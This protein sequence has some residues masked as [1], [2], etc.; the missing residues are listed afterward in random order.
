M[1]MILAYLGVK[2]KDYVN[3]STSYNTR[4]FFLYILF[5][6]LLTTIGAISIYFIFHAY[7]VVMLFLSCI[8]FML[9]D[10]YKSLIRLL[11][12]GDRKLLDILG[13]SKNQYAMAKE[14]SRK[15]FI[16][17]FSIWTNLILAIC[18]FIFENILF[19][20][21]YMM[22]TFISFYLS[23]VLRIK[24]IELYLYKIRFLTR[25]FLFLSNIDFLVPI[26]TGLILYVYFKNMYREL[27]LTLFD[28][29]IL[30]FFSSLFFFFIIGFIIHRILRKCKKRFLATGVYEFFSLSFS[31]Q[32]SKEK[33][34][35]SKLYPRLLQQ[36]WL[37]FRKN[38]P[39]NIHLLFL[40]N[41]TPLIIFYS[42]LFYLNNNP[43]LLSK[44]L[45]ILFLLY[46]PFIF[47]LQTTLSF[48]SIDL[49][50]ET[51]IHFG[52]I[53]KFI[54]W[55]VLFRTLTS[56]LLNNLFGAILSCSII[57]FL[58]VSVRF[59]ITFIIALFTFAL[60][61]SPAG[62][63]STALFPNYKWE[64]ITDIPTTYASI[65]NNIV[66][67]SIG[68]I[69]AAFVWAALYTSPTFIL[70]MVIFNCTVCFFLIMYAG[71]FTKK[72]LF[73]SKASKSKLFME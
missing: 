9:L 72:R 62:P 23:L 24:I 7:S 56:L 51:M 1:K 32:D 60:V 41:I 30:M 20:L 45:A 47:F 22:L 29:T 63:L 4:K 64:Q 55:K 46:S 61:V 67:S 10:T 68:L 50:G 49:D 2:V 27:S 26:L 21:I 39:V 34:R 40:I 48:S 25:R 8:S 44:Y 15:I 18:Y 70:W 36:E 52:Y 6:F 53:K 66:I 73:Y 17:F 14:L 57:L 37:I 35:S 43:E 13:Y 59:H 33:H 3:H 5:W 16:L 69:N 12:S 65:I 38:L 31:A 42:I 19:G 58:D 71:Y 28:F 11:D 54:K